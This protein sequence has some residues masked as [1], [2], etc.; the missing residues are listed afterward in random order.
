VKFI[1]DNTIVISDVFYTIIPIKEIY[2]DIDIHKQSFYIYISFIKNG[3]KETF[4][5]IGQHSVKH[6]KDVKLYHGSGTLFK[7]FYNKYKSSC[8]TFIICKCK[9]H[10]ELSITENFIVDNKVLDD[11]PY[12]LNILIGGE[13][14]KFFKNKSTIPSELRSLRIKLYQQTHKKENEERI[15]KMRETVR[16]KEYRLFLSKCQKSR[17]TKEWLKKMNDGYKKWISID[18]NKR[19]VGNE[20]RTYFKEHPEIIKRSI[21][22]RNQ[23]YAINPSLKQKMIDK[24][25]MWLKDKSKLSKR[26]TKWK[27]TYHKNDKIYGM[28]DLDNNLINIFTRTD[29]L[30]DFI[31]NNNLNKCK[32]KKYAVNSFYS[33]FNRG[34]EIIY[35][36]KWKI[37]KNISDND[38]HLIYK[39]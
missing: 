1:D 28:Y 7:R 12:S 4:Y 13:E 26:G 27:N 25:H 34:K 39:P 23:T 33:T 35:G 11:K 10:R 31:F 14:Y 24:G 15:R 29:Y 2:E 9:N 38:K 5:Y 22:K 8:K 3:N 36:Y 30:A 17:L 37:I 21:D 32:N 20:R 16:N 18:E 19:K 6:K